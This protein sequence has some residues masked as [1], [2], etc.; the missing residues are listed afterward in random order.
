M[1]GRFVG[2]FLMKFVTP[3]RLLLAYAIASA[4]LSVAAMFC[5]GLLPI[6]AVVGIAF[7]MSIMFPTIVSLGIPNA[8]SATEMRS[9]LIIMPIV[10]GTILPIL[11]GTLSDRT[12]DVQHGY[13]VPL[14]SFLVIGWFA[15]TAIR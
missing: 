7:F 14:L 9:S 11:F 8:G 15:W 13:A 6:F 3:A 1:L 12:G 4:A 10:C 2:T 5:S